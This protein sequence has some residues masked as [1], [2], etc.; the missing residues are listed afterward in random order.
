MALRNL[1]VAFKHFFRRCK[2]GD[3]KKGFPQF[4]SRRKGIGGFQL[5]ESI[6]VFEDRIQLPR[7]GTIRLKERGYLPTGSPKSASITEQ[8]GHWF[9]SILAEEPAAPKS[10]SKE[11]LGID[12][13][14]SRLAT[15][16]DGTVFENPK[17]L[18]AAERTLRT[19]QKAV[20]RKVKGSRNRRKAA[21]RLAK[22]HYRISNIRR[23]AIHKATTAAIA[24]QPG[25]I[26]VESLNVKGMMKNHCLA[27]SIADAS[28]SEF[29]RQIKYK[30]EWKGIA[31]IEAPT[32]FPSSK[33]CHDC[34][35]VNDELK[36]SD[37]MWT[38]PS[39]GTVHDRDLNAAKNIRDFAVSSTVKA[40]C[41]GSSGQSRSALTKLP[42]GQEPNTVYPNVG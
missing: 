30:A 38:C 7:I 24:K 31:V 32:F 17:A 9:V 23:D 6:H 26:V 20:S 2:N 41:H 28:M 1:D 37:R 14:V 15:L 40:C 11:V 19:R 5:T 4:K 42:P 8:A 3:K 34:G 22:L 16:S 10:K 36:L 27:K 21:K 25:I 35:Y 29:L 13:G 33:T 12:V 18:K 39:C